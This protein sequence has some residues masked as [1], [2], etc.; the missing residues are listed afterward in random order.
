MYFNEIL[1]IQISEFIGNFVSSD[2][3]HEIAFSSFFIQIPP[4]KVIQHPFQ[5]WVIFV[6]CAKINMEIVN[7]IL[8]ASIF[9]FLVSF[10]IVWLIRKRKRNKKLEHYRYEE[11]LF[12]VDT[13]G[14]IVKTFNYM[15]RLNTTDAITFLYNT[16]SIQ[17]VDDYLALAKTFDNDI[18]LLD[19]IET[20][21]ISTYGLI[22]TLRY[23]YMLHVTLKIIHKYDLEVD[24]DKQ[25]LYADTLNMLDKLRGIKC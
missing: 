2:S 7:I 8:T 18:Q 19:K 17:L 25:Q 16:K 12:L 6:Y 4:S 5:C 21:D 24:G 14:D 15:L 20:T 11:C 10:V 3:N 23:R 1:E 22:F 13:C 9:L